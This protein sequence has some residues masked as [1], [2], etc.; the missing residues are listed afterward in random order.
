MGQGDL[1][2]DILED[3]F[4]LRQLPRADGPAGQA[5]H[6]GGDDGPAVLLQLPEVVLCRRILQHMGIHGRS[7]E[8]GAAAGQEGGAEHIVPQA[9]GDLGA[10]IG[11]GGG[12]DHQIRPVRQ[13]DML[14]LIHRESVKGIRIR[15]PGGEVLE[16]ERRD[17]LRR[18]LRHHHVHLGMELHQGRCQIRRLV[19]RDPPG[20][21][22][23][24]GFPFQHVR[25]LPW[26]VS[27]GASLYP[28]AG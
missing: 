2:Q 11:G 5:P 23:Q 28:R 9:V 19:G 24:H 1:P 14:H 25:R 12:N 4:R 6:R 18:V 3:G 21:P 27:F 8:P 10:D 7:N 22:Q 20:D 16:G 13:G 17:E 26:L 15:L